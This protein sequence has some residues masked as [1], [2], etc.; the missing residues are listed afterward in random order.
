MNKILECLSLHRKSMSDSILSLY[1]SVVP[2]YSARNRYFY[3]QITLYHFSKKN[4]KVT[5]TSVLAWLLSK[6]WCR[7]F[8]SL[9]RS[10]SS[11]QGKLEMT[12]E[13]V[14]E[15][16]HEERPAGHGRD[17]PNMNPKLEDPRLV[18]GP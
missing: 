3:D 11:P 13:I 10:P 6:P 5:L 12:L 4:H 1:V 15:S 9:I 17:E 7:A 8:V 14:T 2:T 16:E 18:P